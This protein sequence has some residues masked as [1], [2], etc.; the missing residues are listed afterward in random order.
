MRSGTRRVCQAL[1][2][3]GL[4]L[5]TP[6][7]QSQAVNPVE[8][9]KEINTPSE[10]Y[11]SALFTY[12]QVVNTATQASKAGLLSLEQVRQFEHLRQIARVALNQ[13]ERIIRDSGPTTDITW[14]IGQAI[15]ATTEL[16]LVIGRR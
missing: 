9:V 2:M 16:S 15:Q 11:A 1:L 12:T 10:A 13:A 4:V 7:C 5:V 3:L 14:W 6:A 8:V